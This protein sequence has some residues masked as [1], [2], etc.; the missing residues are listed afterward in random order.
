[1][2]KEFSKK[3]LDQTKNI[4]ISQ[5]ILAALFTFF[6]RDISAYYYTIP[7]SAAAYAAAIAFYLNKAKLENIFKGKIAFLKFKI[8]LKAKLTDEVFAEIEQDLSSMD[9][10]FNMKIDTEISEAMQESTTINI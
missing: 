10:N 5:L 1:M 9:D 6:E 2:K 8:K 7:A 3:L 4:F